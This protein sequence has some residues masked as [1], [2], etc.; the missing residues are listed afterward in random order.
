MFFAMGELGTAEFGGVKGK[1][2]WGISTGGGFP[3]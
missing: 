1:L 3:S 2:D